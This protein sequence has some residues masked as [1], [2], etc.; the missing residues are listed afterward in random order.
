MSAEGVSN[1]R[2]T[3]ALLSPDPE[4]GRLRQE[5][6]GGADRQRGGR[7]EEG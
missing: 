3:G 7:E 1:I 5:E 2:L 4:E 6:G